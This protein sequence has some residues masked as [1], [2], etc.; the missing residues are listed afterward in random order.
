MATPPRRIGLSGVEVVSPE[1]RAALG[2]KRPTNLLD[3]TQTVNRPSGLGA[4]LF[5]ESTIQ[6][7]QARTMMGGSPLSKGIAP[8][9][10]R[11]VT[12]TETGLDENALGILMNAAGMLPQPRPQGL[13]ETVMNQRELQTQQDDFKE[14][15]QA[16]VINDKLQSIE[17][18]VVDVEKVVDQI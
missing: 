11:S 3:P 9:F 6:S 16:K 12:G 5:P 7:G 1:L 13:K 10:A 8:A 18:D 2:I 14:L 4:I 15:D 17:E